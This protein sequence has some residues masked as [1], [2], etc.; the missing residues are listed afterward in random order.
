MAMGGYNWNQMYDVAG[1]AAGL[2]VQ[3]TPEERQM[4]KMV[5]MV[6]A[7]EAT[8][9][10]GDPEYYQ[11]IK[12]LA[13]QAGIPIKE[14]KTNPFRMAKA[15]LLSFADMALLG[16]V[17]NDW[18]TPLNKEEEMMSGIG[19]VAGLINPYGGAGA[20]ARG[21]WG[22]LRNMPRWARGLAK[23]GLG[24]SGYRRA[25]QAY[26]GPQGW[27]RNWRGNRGDTFMTKADRKYNQKAATGSN[28][29]VKAGVRIHLNF[30]KL[31]RLYLNNYL[32]VGLFL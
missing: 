1:A 9:Y 2:N 21:A 28:L 26:T 6:K 7:A 16:L 17:P 23:R 29:P 15:G 8:N 19:S 31:R 22:G 13:M 32:M 5:N 4:K 14:F 27:M 18:Y 3:M 11:Q 12:T 25:S 10:D 30:M 24:Q 20:L